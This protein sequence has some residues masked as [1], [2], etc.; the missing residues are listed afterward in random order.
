MIFSTIPTAA[1]SVSP[2]WF[3]KIV[4]TTKDTWMK[5]SCRHTGTPTFKIFFMVMR[6]G[7]KSDF[8]KRIPPFLFKTQPS[9][10]LLC[11][12]R[13][14]GSTGCIQPQQS[15][16]QILQSDI[17]RTCHRNKIHR[18]LRIPHPPENGADNIIS[19]DKR[20]PY[21]TNSQIT[22]CPFYCLRRSR[23][24]PNNWSDKHK[25]DCHSSNLSP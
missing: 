9:I 22:N 20:N 24:N 12:R 4:I 13:S 14:K 17:G 25:K 3:A 7:L 19:C 23:H 5:P 8:S 6:F 11:A 18:A 2:R 15:N 21:K 1:A 10:Q 16:K